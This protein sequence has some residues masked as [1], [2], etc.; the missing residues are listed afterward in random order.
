MKGTPL[1]FYASRIMGR[2]TGNTGFRSAAYKSDGSEAV[3]AEEKAFQES[4]KDLPDE[5]KNVVIAARKAFNDKILSI[6]AKML[7]K[8][9]AEPIISKA[10]DEFKDVPEALKEMKN[11]LALHG[12]SLKALKSG[13]D[14]SSPASFKSQVHKMI[15]DNADAIK[16]S[17][18]GEPVELEIKA[19]TTV[20]T[21]SST[22]PTAPPDLV[23]VQMAPPSEVGI[24]E[25]NLMD[26]V[27]T[28]DTSLAAY[29]YT[30][31]LPKEGDFSFQNGEGALKDQLDFKTETRYATPVTLAAW[32]ELSTQAV[33]DIPGLQSIATGLLWKKHNR[34]KAKAILFGTNTNGEPKGA[35][36]YASALTCPTAL[37]NKVEKPTIM[38]L[39]NGVATVI[40]TT[41]DYQDQIGYKANIALMHPYDFY[42]EF[43]A[44]KDGFGHALYP[45]AQ[46]FGQVTIGAMTIRPWED[47][48]AGSIFVGDMS[49]YNVSNYIGYK[50]IIGRIND[51]LVKNK[52]V[53]LAE[54]RFHA[55]VKKLDEKAFVYDTIENIRGLLQKSA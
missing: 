24:R 6:Q 37:Q 35:T 21:G 27:T 55:F 49:K 28:I 43:V 14:Q 52:F 20:T 39:I 17:L 46:L 36:L 26:L 16:S 23:G 42:L 44:A 7:T 15:A 40:F 25:D 48:T 13:A 41:H 34:K 19:V 33:E 9:E 51:N 50:I 54:S 30:E 10:L 1:K 22:N 18:K 53:I 12:N 47:M 31:S 8:E 11:L 29:P 38:D 5:T 4:I 3:E 45:T 32:E 2:N